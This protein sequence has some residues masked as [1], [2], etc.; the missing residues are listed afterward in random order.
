[1]GSK[2]LTRDVVCADAKEQ[3]TRKRE[4]V[5]NKTAVVGLLIAMVSAVRAETPA[6]VSVAVAAANK[7]TIISAL[8]Y[9]ITAPGTYILLS[10]LGVP[11][12][13][14]VP[15]ITINSP[16]KVTLNLNGYALQ[17][18]SSSEG[19]TGIQVLS[20][21]V[22]VENGTISQC[23]FGLVAGPVNGNASMGDPPYLTNI[24]IRNIQFAFD[25]QY[26]LLLTNING[27][28]VSD[29]QFT[30]GRDG[31]ISVG[32]CIHMQFSNLA[33]TGTF[34]E[35]FSI[36]GFATGNPVIINK[37]SEPVSN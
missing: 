20:S 26:E 34:Y 18:P 17:N 14:T 2:N 10:N 9:S 5:K 12:G 11:L 23:F 35:V 15:A 6:H 30:G 21:N 13:Q 33:I 16:G 1:M 27:G 4:R 28:S 36:G 24:V 8:P 37:V 25:F 29:C 22:T 19:P 32:G 31:A 7:Y 3:T